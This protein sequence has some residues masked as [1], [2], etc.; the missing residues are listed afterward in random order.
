MLEFFGAVIKG[1]RERASA[2]VVGWS[3]AAVASSTGFI[4]YTHISALTVYLNQSWKS[5][6]LYPLCVDGQIAIGSVILMEVKGKN[7][8]WGLI[9]FLPGLAESLIANWASGWAGHNLGAAL[10]A[11][12]PAQAFA[13]STFLFEMWLRY[14][15]RTQQP[16]AGEAAPAAAV[17]DELSLQAPE[18]AAPAAPEAG[19]ALVHVHPAPAEAPWGLVSPAAASVPQPAAPVPS[20]PFP[21]LAGGP[22][23]ALA[24]RPARR[25]AAASV[26][27]DR[28]P[29]PADEAELAALVRSMSRNELFRQYQ[30][31]KHEADKLRKQYLNEEVTADVA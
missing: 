8:W 31:S 9:G 15:R 20:L 10:W 23:M 5:A 1:A 19:P 12:V 25:R 17:L 21:L 16:H 28:A 6:H 2:L 29:L 4:S 7:R 3:L 18:P 24:D 30:V 13:C 11:T 22:S 14:R 26:S 27:I